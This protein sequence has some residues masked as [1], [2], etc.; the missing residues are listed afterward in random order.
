MFVRRW[1]MIL[2]F[3]KPYIVSAVELVMLMFTDRL[4]D[5]HLTNYM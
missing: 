3:D 5:P 2:L 4:E 1:G